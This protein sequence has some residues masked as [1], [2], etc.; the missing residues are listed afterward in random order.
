METR[1]I[2]T[3]ADL[4]SARGLLEGHARVALDLEAAGFHRYSDRL[5]LV[6]LTAGSTTLLLDPFPLDLGAFLGP[7]LE[8]PDVEVVMHGA[9]YDLRLL[10]RDL[11]IRLTGLFDTQ[12]A[13]SLLGQDGLGLSSL[14]ERYFDVRLSKKFQRA[15][16]AQRPLGEA[17]LEYAALDTKYLEGLADRLSEE[18][19]RAGRME[20]A[21]EEFRALE[22]I[23]FEPP[24]EEDP[25]VRVKATRDLTPREIDRLRAALE[26]RDRIAKARD[27]APFRIAHD[28]VLVEI[29]RQSPRSLDELAGM[30]GLNDR[31]ARSE[32]ADLLQRLREVEA[33]SEDAVKGYPRQ[34]RGPGRDRPTPEEE[35]RLDRM[36]Q[37][38]NQRAEELGIARGVLLPNS[39]L[40]TLAK[41]P[42]QRSADVLAAPGIRRWQGQAVGEVILEAVGAAAGSRG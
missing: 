27:R 39:V 7:I 6:Q 32:G 9:D 12:V 4:E 11:G 19:D 30:G 10:D 29:A 28:G 34:R 36:K 37:A 2:D 13:A 38:R 22:S 14:L 24:A 16:W 18:L 23:R 1:Y 25:V 17:M 35:E 8:D 33:R 5:S 31:L 40:E 15:D 26:W 21:R 20:W 41:N 42:P 3:E